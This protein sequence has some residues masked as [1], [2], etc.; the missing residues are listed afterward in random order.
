MD[1]LKPPRTLCLDSSNIAKTWKSWRDE[2]LLYVDLTLTDA[3]DT[4]KVKL[5]S[6]LVGD[7]GRDL[8]DTLMGDTAHDAWKL[9]DII[10]KFDDHCNPGVNET[11]ERYRFFT[12]SQ[13]A[14]ESIDS[15][16]TELRL[17]AKTC[18][19]GTLR[20]SLIR[21]RIVC[22][23]N[24][25]SMRER[26]LREKNLTL[27]TCLQLCRAAELSKENVK[28]ITSAIAEEVHA[29]QGAQYQ[30]TDSNTVQCKF[31]G[32]THEKR[33]EK[34]PA[35][36]K[37]CAKC[38]TKNHFAAKCKAKM[39]RTRHKHVS[40]IK[41][42]SVS[43]EYEDIASVTSTE[44]EKVDTEETR[45]GEDKGIKERKETGTVKK[46]SQLLYAGMLLGKNTVQFQID[47]G[48]SCNII[49]INLLNPDVELEHTKSVLV[50]YNK[51]KLRPIGKCKVK[52]R[53]PR[54]NKLYRLEFQVV[55]TDG[56]M[57]LIGRKASEAMKLIK[58]HYENIMAIDSIVTTAKKP[59]IE[60]WTV[61]QIKVRYADVFTGDGC[62]EGKYK[63]EIDSTVKPVQ[64]PKRRVPVALMKPLKEELQNLQQR[65]IITP[66]EC[67]TEWI[68]AMVVVQKQNGKPRVCIDPKPLNKA[69]RRSHF[70]LPT[71]EDILPDLSKAKVFT[72]CDV[73]S[74]FW[75]VQ[76][77]EESSYVTTFATPFGRYRWLRMP[78][79]ISTAPEIF[80]RKLMQALDNMPGLYIIADDI[81]ITGQGETEEEAEQDHDR[82]LK[83]FLDRCREKNIKLNADKF[84]LK[85]KETTYIGH[86]LTAEGLKP[87]PEKVRAVEQMPAPTDVKA[88]QRLIG[89]AN[90]LTKFCPHLSDHCK[91][92]RDL[93]HKDS[94]WT[95]NAEQEE[96]FLNLKKTITN[97]P[98]LKYYNPEEEL[99]LQSDASDTGLGAALMQMGK[100]VA[101]ASRALTKTEQ[102]YAQIEKEFLA[103]VFG[104]EKFHQYTYGHKVTVQSDHKPLET[105]VRKPLLS[106]PKRLQGMMLRIQ[107]YDTEVLYVPGRDLVLA[108]TLSRAYPLEDVPVEAELETVNMVQHLPISA[109]RLQEIKTATEQDK[110]L[111]LL[112]NTM[113]WGWPKNK[114]HVP[115]EIRPYFSFQEELSHQRGIV[116]RGER[117]V[118]PD[119]MRTE[120]TSRIHASHLGVEGCLR[121]ARECVYW[122]GMNEQIKQYIA[123]CDICRSMD[124]KQQKETLIPH[125][126]PNR[127]WAKVG[128]D[129][130]M[131]DNRDYLITVDYFSNFWEIDYLAD[132]K[133]TTVIKKLKAHFARQGIPDIVISD[134]GP[135]YVSQEFKKFS[136]LWGFQHKTS[137]PGYPQSNGKAESAVK[138]AKRLLHKAKAAGQDP[139]L[140]LLDHRNTPSL[141]LN[142]SPAQRLLSRRTKT[143][144]PMKSSLLKPR[145]VQVQ[146][147]L[148]NR[149]THP[150]TY[151]NRS[152]KDLPVLKSGDSVRIQPFPPQTVWRCG[153]VLSRIDERSYEI[154]LQSGSVIRRNR[155]HLRLVPERAVRDPVDV[156][157]NF[158]IQAEVTGQGQA[159]SVHPPHRVLDHT[160]KDTGSGETT[161]TTR[162]GRTVKMP[163]H[164][165]DYVLSHR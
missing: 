134:N 152:A 55:D 154:Q 69:L 143:L 145:V 151:Y 28:A 105:I 142:T 83:Q 53:N 97:A 121:R 72:V 24:N 61:E 74:G 45:C 75:H 3:D 57:P 59:A 109:D 150:S 128:T 21:D 118:I 100:P 114:L 1:G 68:S 46:D 82:K 35:F 14:S 102:G 44:M 9:E 22:G 163:Q 116:F 159:G 156:D 31:C 7:S 127:P 50:M 16:V 51:S 62:L 67:S 77:E 139:Y 12:R 36:G 104:L 86:R 98:V 124:D 135:Q 27:D 115:S 92:L 48:A 37:K 5:F 91:V 85:Q 157:I 113:T 10:K 99:T 160:P 30:S 34:C 95:W 161:V 123:K 32:K 106:A 52:I 6:Y 137:S 8:L 84:R 138:T 26:L 54:N 25:T 110:T 162:A 56:V 126:V 43:D 87:D 64:L 19:F 88:V 40:N 90:Y 79:G 17:L 108:D 13:G 140:S 146:Q 117:A 23:G 164:Y 141:G 148:M 107:K 158:P 78:M 80:Q 149:Q 101:F 29:V 111:Q 81:L 38:G 47:C 42:E 125:E 130:F 11:V 18:N 39:D 63:M 94:E 103:M 70:P 33:K 165:K 76:L 58:V 96:A 20:D 155:R 120:I 153:K 71:I 4:Q 144:L 93:T 122:L 129:L 15:Y 147:E 66:V 65:G 132:T 73:K 89:M 133:S 49:P 112:I 41:T 2:F 119:A 136:Q 60:P 131:F